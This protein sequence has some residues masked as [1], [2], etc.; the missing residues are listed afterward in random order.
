MSQTTTKT[1]IAISATTRNILSVAKI[2]PATVTIS[3]MARI[4]LIIV[5]MI[6]PMYLVC[7]R[8]V[9]GEPGH[10][11]PGLK[12]ASLMNTSQSFS[13]HLGLPIQ[14]QIISVGHTI[15]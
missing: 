3:Q 10:M 9:A 15:R 2:P 1:A 11:F 5:P 12:R 8:P 7:A 14:N 4:A 13:A 6:R